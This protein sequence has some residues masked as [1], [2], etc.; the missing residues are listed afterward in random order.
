[1]SSLR[2]LTDFWFA[3]APATRLA[4][5]RILVG[6]FALW[7]M[8]P[9]YEMHLSVAGTSADLLA[10]VGAASILISP[11]PVVAFQA[12]LLLT[13]V[14]GAAFTLG[15]RYSITGPAYGLLLW[16]V[17]CYR[18]SWSMIYH[19][20][21]L[22][23][24]HTLILGF[25]RSADAWSVDNFFRRR[26][27]DSAPCR[28][29]SDWRYG[30]PLR[31][32]CAV[33]VCAYFLAGVAKVAGPLGWSW[34]HGEA[35]RSQ[36][37]VDGLRKELLGDGAAPLTFQLYGQ[38]WLFTVIGVMTLV[39]ELGAPAAMFHRWIGRCW[40]V[41]ALGM[42]WGILFLMDIK[43][44]YSLSGIIFAAFFPLER[45]VRWVLSRAEKFRRPS[46]A[47]AGSQTLEAP[48]GIGVS[49]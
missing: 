30:W 3:P 40:A 29:D 31:L 32:I 20:D 10:P 8:I 25:A 9:R 34:I 43:F 23:V 21:N 27:G 15:W 13:Y 28:L 46:P 2:H 38:V 41:A 36:L 11:M 45:L 19:S 22:L 12:L 35:L 1:M 49:G 44:E 42:H 17:L 39:L 7:H 14:L 24:L 48:K 33:T 16:F 4:A 37:A 47:G 6:L 5:V 26:A 18:N